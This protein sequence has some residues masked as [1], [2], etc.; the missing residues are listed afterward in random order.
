[1][2]KAR[3]ET[4][5]VVTETV[6]LEL[7]PEEAETLL[8]IMGKVAGSTTLS[9]RKH[10][11]AVSSALHSAGVSSGG[12]VRMNLGGYTYDMDLGGQPGSLL[13]GSLRFNNYP[14]GG[15]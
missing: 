4:K 10:T 14:N 7:S 12:S 8:A 3:T 9:P 13:G 11:D 6:L 5:T 2:A 15:K 1:M